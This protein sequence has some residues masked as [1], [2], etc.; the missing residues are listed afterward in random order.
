MEIQYHSKTR[1]T[2][3]WVAEKINMSH[4]TFLNNHTQKNNL[5]I[6]QKYI[7]KGK[8]KIIHW[9]ENSGQKK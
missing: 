7:E 1:E 9:L 8:N 5:D 3:I 6:P 4:F 2:L